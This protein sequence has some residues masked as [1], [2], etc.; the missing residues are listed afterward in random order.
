[1]IVT[2]AATLGAAAVLAV[3]ASG[4]GEDFESISRL[5]SLRVLALQAEPAA[6]A[7]GET[8]TLSALVYTPPGV[9]VTSYAWSWCPFAGPA[10][11]GS[12]CL[13]TEAELAAM[14]VQVPPF[15]LGSAETASFEHN[16]DPAL[17]ASICGATAPGQPSFLDCE[18]GLPVQVKLVVTAGAEQI[19][20]INTLRLRFAPEHEANANPPI[21]GLSAVVAGTEVPV[22]LAPGP[23]LLR[24]EETDVRA[25]VQPTASEGYMGLDEM[26]L[27]VAVREALVLS[28]FVESGELK[29]ERTAFIDGVVELAPALEN[30]WEPGLLKDYDRPTADLIVVIRD[31]RGGVSWRRGTVTLGDAP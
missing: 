24:G 15:D 17:L 5:S 30:V 4:C 3:A 10:S 1:M 22:D 8:S 7:N 23:T 27:P 16:L 11:E 21:D 29:D 13:V 19:T 26:G 2:R 12:K 20:A 9:S 14:G 31:S 25:Q 28:W 6:P 18:G